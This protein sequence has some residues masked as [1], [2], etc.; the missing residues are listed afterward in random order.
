VTDGDPDNRD[1]TFVIR[2]GRPRV[3][4][5]YQLRATLHGEDPE[6]VLDA[7]RAIVL[8]W[9]Q[10]KLGRTLPKSIVE[11]GTDSEELHGQRIETVSLEA[12]REWCLRYSRPDEPLGDRPAEAGRTW[13]TDVALVVRR[14][15]VDLA[16][17]DRCSSTQSENSS[18]P[19]FR[20]RFVRDLVDRVD[21]RDVARLSCDPWVV[22]SDSQLDVLHAL[23]QERRRRLPV[24]L[25]TEVDERRV[26]IETHRFLLDERWLASNCRGI[27]HVF[28][29][30][31]AQSFGWSGRVGRTW[32]AFQGAVRIYRPGLDFAEDAL[33]DHPL[34]M[35][36]RILAFAEDGRTMEE[37]FQR[38]LR[39]QLVAHSA[40]DEPD[41]TDFRF[42]REAKAL[43]AEALRRSA[44]EG[45]DHQALYEQEID[46]LKRRAHDSDELAQAYHDDAKQAVQERDQ[47]LDEN[48]RLRARIDMLSSGLRRG[49]G[50]DAADAER[51]ATLADIPEWVERH[52]AGSLVLHSRATRGLKSA[53]F[54]DAGLIADALGLLATAYRDVCMGDPQA[55]ERLEADLHKFGLQCTPSGDETSL[56][57]FGDAYLIRWP[58]ADSSQRLLRMHLKNNGNTRDP[59]RCLRI[60]FLW[61]PDTLQVVVG[62]LP[63]HLPNTHT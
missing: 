5:T 52:L 43:H 23:V 4:T 6:Q 47:V 28:V 62:W 19:R 48:R 22:E 2:S 38:H 12:G 35:P 56:G 34:V 13:S 9:I 14:E 37:A 63:S 30:P 61:D 20:P 36:E 24:V 39:D 11:G 1:A 7:A 41:W 44:T 8:G 59:R 33:H 21:V 15:H 3:R 57:R 50:N 26:P 53:T 42:V 49:A 10:E 46:Q 58:F 18:P 60:Y 32:S 17:R 31:R 29:M 54:D 55:R 51:P 25:L 40:A 16:V 45:A 27:A